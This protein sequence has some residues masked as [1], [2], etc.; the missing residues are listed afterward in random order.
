LA[1]LFWPAVGA[2]AIVR[3]RI[4]CLVVSGDGAVT[5]VEIKTGGPRPEHARQLDIYR[6]AVE[7]LWPG[8]AVHVRLVYS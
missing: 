6:A 8:R 7:A 5:I 4:D 3:G 1:I 2:V